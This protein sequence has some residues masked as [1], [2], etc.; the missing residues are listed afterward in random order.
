MPHPVENKTRAIV[1]LRRI[2]AQAD[3]LMRMIEAEKG[4]NEVLQELL[5]MRSII[6]TLMTDVLEGHLLESFGHAD[7]TLESVSKADVEHERI[8]ATIDETITLVRSY[9][10]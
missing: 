9:L 3:S 8:H 2:Y 10:K 6:N 5:T 1:R 7:C 4:S